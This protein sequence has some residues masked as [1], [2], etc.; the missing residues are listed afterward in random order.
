[1]PSTT[2]LSPAID[3][4]TEYAFKLQDTTTGTIKA[5]S[6][7]DSDLST[8]YDTLLHTIKQS[9]DLHA[10]RV[11]HAKNTSTE[12]IE[13]VERA[14][15]EAA[16][17]G[18]RVIKEA[19]KERIELSDLKR[20][21]EENEEEFK[22]RKKEWE[23]KVA[24]AADVKNK[25]SNKIKINVGGHRYEVSIDTLLRQEG[26]FF[27]SC[28]SGRWLIEPEEDGAFFI[29]RDG[30]LYSYIFNFLRDGDECVLPADSEKRQRLVKEA[31]YLN[32]E[33]LKTKVNSPSGTPV[34]KP[35]N[36][37]NMYCPYCLNMGH[38]QRAVPWNEQ[39]QQYACPN[40]HHGF[41]IFKS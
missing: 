38:G 6:S 28:F 22:A 35:N 1:M 39:K 27:H 33:A 4:L 13:K 37:A 19:E 32:F 41:A 16:E 25:Q 29:D 2:Q 9:R 31:E 36:W 5:F 26:T 34:G 11:A 17:S 18:K 8:M 24:Y 7:L 12:S 30:E 15:R 40:C 14:G 23:K 3:E 20:K 21:L 10:T